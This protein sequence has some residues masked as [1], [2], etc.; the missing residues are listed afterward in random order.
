MV[1]VQN[2]LSEDIVIRLRVGR[3]QL[4]EILYLCTY[5][6]CVKSFIACSILLTWPTFVTP[7]SLRSLRANVSSSLP[8]MSCFSKLSMYSDSWRV[9]SQVATS[10][11]PQEATSRFWLLWALA[12]GLAL[13]FSQNRPLRLCSACWKEK[14]VL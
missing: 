5:R 13:N 12:D 10:W 11:V 4:L 2:C 3:A 14:W 9:S 8:R 7:K 1:L 6:P